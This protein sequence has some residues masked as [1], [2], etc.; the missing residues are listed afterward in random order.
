M[1]AQNQ[2][3]EASASL[4]AQ[5]AEAEE[6]QDQD[7]QL[8]PQEFF[9]EFDL[10]DAWGEVKDEFQHGTVRSKAASSAKLLGKSLWNAGL[11]IAKNLPEHLEKAKANI[12][13]QNEEREKKK[14]IYEHKS[15]GELYDIA[16]NGSDDIERRIAYDILKVRKAEH[17][18][19]KGQA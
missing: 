3:A 13:K 9:R 18:A 14:L 1:P 16:K 15:S 4:L 17:D 10:K 12:E 8:P 7:D 2:R 6:M 11:S 5:S 19:K